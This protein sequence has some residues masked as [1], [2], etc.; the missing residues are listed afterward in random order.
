MRLYLAGPMSGRP[1]FNYP[2]FEKWYVQLA[3]AG[4]WVE[5]PHHRDDAAL[6]EACL[7]SVGGDPADLPGFDMVGAVARNAAGV[8]R[9]DGVAVLDG[10]QRSAGARM[11]VEVAHRLNLPVA[12]AWLWRSHKPT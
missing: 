12:P 3:T 1:R 7:A 4:F 10:W 2:E 8:S 5:S 9:S 11:E 6:R